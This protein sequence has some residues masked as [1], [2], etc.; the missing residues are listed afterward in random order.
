MKS[1]SSR[2]SG[3][4]GEERKTERKQQQRL[5]FSLL[6]T[7]CTNVENTEPQ[8]RVMFEQWIVFKL[9]KLFLQ[10]YRGI[11]KWSLYSNVRER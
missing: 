5:H 6:M 8:K 7:C 4:G 9:L 10:I 1:S 2:C 11:V 3:G